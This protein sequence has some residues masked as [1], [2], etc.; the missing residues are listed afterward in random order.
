MTQCVMHK[1]LF[2]DITAKNEPKKIHLGIYRELDL[3]LIKASSNLY[4]CVFLN[5]YDNALS[6]CMTFQ[7]LILHALNFRM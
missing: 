3:S 7:K 4:K 5:I 6:S 1:Y 2:V